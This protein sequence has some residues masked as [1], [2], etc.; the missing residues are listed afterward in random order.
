MMFGS[1]LRNFNKN[2]ILL[3]KENENGRNLSARIHK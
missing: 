2:A 1:M 3:E